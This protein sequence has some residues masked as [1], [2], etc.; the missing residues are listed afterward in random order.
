MASSFPSSLLDS[1]VEFQ[2]PDAER[3][4]EEHESPKIVTSVR[5]NPLK[6]CAQF[7]HEE[8]ISW[9][10]NGRYLSKRPSF[11]SDPLFH[12]GC[13]YVQ[14]A[15]SMFLE[16]AIRHCVSLEERLRVL[17]L[18]AAPG[19]KSTLIASVINEHS[20]LLSN[21]IIKSRAPVLADN[22][23]RWGNINTVVS[24][25]DPRDIGKLEA[26]FDL[27]VVD[28][29]C[30]GSGMFRKDPAA[31]DQWSESNVQLCSER[32]QRILSDALPALKKGGVLIYSTCS[33][34]EK[35]NEQIA[36]WLCA[37]HQMEPLKLPLPESWGVVE[38][39]SPQ[40]SC[41]GYRFYPHRL[42]GEG[43]FMAC[44]VKRGGDEQ[45]AFK[46]FKPAKANMTEQAVI[47]GWLAD[48]DRL[49]LLP[50]KEGYTVIHKEFLD[51]ITY[52]QSRLY[53]KKAGVFAGKVL[54]RDLVPEHELAL[55][56]ILSRNIQRLELDLTSAIRYLR[57]DSL[58]LRYDIRGW[59]LMCFQEKALGWAKLLPNRVNN[60]Y[61][62]ELRIIKEIDV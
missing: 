5:L 30:S 31:I 60:Y 24:N 3:F 38:T 15:S 28:A 35:E 56:N 45:P 1:L 19:G 2:L 37:T 4:L 41:P 57:R 18:C 55:S 29:P 8:H 10:E 26:F 48:D 52:L 59:T 32:Q 6:P 50:V 25:N 40:H 51:E 61:P 14:E 11:I 13:Y 58:D 12:A 22:L 49:W 43:L 34:S 17:D 9:C 7:D 47:K 39:S 42:K 62:K 53:L 21:E 16:H 44:F 23:S 33:Y 46:P 54:G 20:L 36:D 27:M